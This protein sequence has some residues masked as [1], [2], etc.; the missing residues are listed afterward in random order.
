MEAF[1]SMCLWKKN[2][3]NSRISNIY[4]CR[5]QHKW[6]EKPLLTTHVR[7]LPS[8]LVLSCIRA[9]HNLRIRSDVC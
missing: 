8:S 7:L 1:T 6:E 3:P 2:L 4:V 5:T 9:P